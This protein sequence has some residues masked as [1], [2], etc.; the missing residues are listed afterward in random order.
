MICATILSGCNNTEIT[1]NDTEPATTT[2]TVITTVAPATQTTETTVTPTTES[3]TTVAKTEVETEPQVTKPQ[4]EAPKVETEKPETN[5]PSNNTN[6]SGNSTTTQKPAQD[7]NNNTSNNKKPSN[8]TSQTVTD[9]TPISHSQLCTDANMNKITSAV[10]TYFVNLGIKDEHLPDWARE[11]FENIYRAETESQTPTLK[12]SCKTN[13]LF[14][15]SDSS[16]YTHP[17]I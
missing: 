3:E 17:K 13:P 8:N 6:N 11:K 12:M 9:D 7:T 4:T 10:N 5:K 14:L 16:I 15:F 1:S 2:S